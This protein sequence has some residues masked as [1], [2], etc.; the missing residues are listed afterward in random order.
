MSSAIIATVNGSDWPH[1][2]AATGTL[3]SP[4]Q[5][6]TRGWSS[7]R[8]QAADG[9][10]AEFN[11][12][13]PHNQ[14]CV[15]CGFGRR[16]HAGYRQDGARQWCCSH[17]GRPRMTVEQWSVERAAEQAKAERQSATV[18]VA[19]V[20]TAKSV[21]ATLATAIGDRDAARAELERLEAAVDPARA[22]IAQLRSAHEAHEAQLASAEAGGAA[23][24]VAMLLGGRQSQSVSL[25]AIRA[26]LEDA[27][28]ELAAAV[29]ARQQIGDRLDVA[30]S[31]VARSER[32][33][34]ELAI[35]VLR[36]DVPAGVVARA[37]RARAEFGKAMRAVCW[38]GAMGVLGDT[39]AH[40][41]LFDSASAWPESADGAPEWEAA[42]A[43]LQ[44]DANTLLPA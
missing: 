41:R 25:S 1:F 10:V 2:D 34:H 22:T 24:I 3:H 13:Y 43:G 30:R 42:L 16:W 15:C 38:L 33:V 5:S 18:A 9:A 37:E 21:R 27:A 40:R 39:A 31:D 23:N 12:S 26:R 36:L 20:P 7:E 19:P 28:G 11:Q 29:A 44:R 6:D 35:E 14:L 32:K 4:D 8:R 17:C